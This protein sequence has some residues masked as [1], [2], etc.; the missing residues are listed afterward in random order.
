MTNQQ[1]V[2]ALRRL[3]YS[4]T[5]TDVIRASEIARPTVYKIIRTGH[6]PDRFRDSLA[7]ALR[8]VHLGTDDNPRSAA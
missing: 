8:S 1:I 5:V 2:N 4:P 3:V 6:V 7:N